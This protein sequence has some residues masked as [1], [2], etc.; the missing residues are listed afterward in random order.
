MKS[1]SH[2]PVFASVAIFA[3]AALATATGAA[4]G[5]GSAQHASAQIVDP[6]GNPIGTA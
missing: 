5:T 4:A 3:M 1:K 6:T 2:R